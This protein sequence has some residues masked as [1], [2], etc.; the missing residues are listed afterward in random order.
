MDTPAKPPKPLTLLR[1][2]EVKRRTGLSTSGL[3]KLMAEG[4]FKR[5]VR[6]AGCV[7]WPEHEV[8]AFIQ[9]RIAERDAKHGD[10]WTSLGDTAAKVIKKL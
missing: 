4:R 7:A 10:T 8:E 5:P 1:R 3:Y 2:E 9:Q 6:M